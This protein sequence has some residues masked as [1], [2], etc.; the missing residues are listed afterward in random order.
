[1]AAPLLIAGITAALSAV[2]NGIGSSA[3]RKRA[4]EAEREANK[5]FARRETNLDNWYNIVKG[6]DYTQTADAQNA[7]REARETV[8][9]T[10]NNAKGTSAVMG[11]TGEVEARE[12]AAANK[13]MGQTVAQINAAGT[14]AKLRADERY[15]QGKNQLSADRARYKTDILTQEAKNIQ[16]AT[17]QFTNSLG[18]F[19]RAAALGTEV[20][21]TVEQAKT[22]I[23]RGNIVPTPQEATTESIYEALYG[24]KIR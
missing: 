11:S 23:A 1:M 10:Y 2:A 8:R 24:R 15:M 3:A 4:K 6:R 14:N 5:E 18:G 19:T 13:M 17:E 20:E 12:K 9:D 7:I 21:P 16:N 22:E